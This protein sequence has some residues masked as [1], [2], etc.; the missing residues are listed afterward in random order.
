MCEMTMVIQDDY[1]VIKV[2]WFSLTSWSSVTVLGD[3]KYFDCRVTNR[4]RWT[5]KGQSRQV[6][7]LEKK[8]KEEE[9]KRPKDKGMQLC[10]LCMITL[11]MP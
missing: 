9:E 7:N 8:R 5:E 1:V 4:R 10:S 6:P 11:S 2:N 3:G